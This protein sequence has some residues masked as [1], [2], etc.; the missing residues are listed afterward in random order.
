MSKGCFD[1]M[2]LMSDFLVL[3]KPEIMTRPGS[4]S[5]NAIKPNGAFLL[6][7]HIN[8][9]SKRSIKSLI[10][11]L[12]VLDVKRTTNSF[13]HHTHIVVY[14]PIGKPELWL[15]LFHWFLFQI[16]QLYRIVKHFTRFALCVANK[17]VASDAV[18][19]PPEFMTYIIFLL[20]LNLLH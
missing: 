19:F 17:R 6:L 18:G 5:N 15:L 20:A 1:F 4:N 10:V 2:F 12:K 11:A 7:V 13:G 16:G 9:W 14:N 8:I 3:L